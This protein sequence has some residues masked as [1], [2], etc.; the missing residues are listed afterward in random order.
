[1]DVVVRAVFPEMSVGPVAN[2]RRWCCGVK[3]TADHERVTIEN[4]IDG[5]LTTISI[6][7]GATG[8]AANTVDP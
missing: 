8:T 7:A 5:R 4:V 3:E 2:V 1:M 6:A